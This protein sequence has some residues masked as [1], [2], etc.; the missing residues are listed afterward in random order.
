MGYPPGFCEHG[1][2]YG[3]GFDYPLNR[4]SDGCTDPEIHAQRDRVRR[5]ILTWVHAIENMPEGHHRTAG[6]RQ[7]LVNTMSVDNG[8][9]NTRL[10]AALNAFDAARSTN[11]DK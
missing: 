8:R 6:L 1:Y 4:A 3:D 11:G 2:L 7:M 5:A 9:D 10:V